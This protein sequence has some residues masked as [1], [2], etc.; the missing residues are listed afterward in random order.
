M[1]ALVIDGHPNPDSLTA[2]LARRYAEGHGDA[3]VVTL[4][5]LD[6]DPVLRFG[7]TRP[8]ELEAD[9]RQTWELLLEAEHV[10]VTTPIWWGSVPSLLKGFFDR[11]LLPKQA[12]RYRPSGLPEGLLKG[13]SGRVV[14][15]TDSPWWWL[16]FVERNMAMHQFQHSTLGFCGI[17]PL[18]A[19]RFGPVHTSRAEQRERWLGKVEELGRADAT[20]RPRRPAR[21][22]PALSIQ[23]TSSPPRTS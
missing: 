2:A 11:T 14:V 18:R 4:R 23:R 13:R 3:T 8:Q 19:T 9:L 5:D 20:R 6:F 21:P 15:T 10:V 1:G 17:A 12:Y 7:Y 16:R 22:H